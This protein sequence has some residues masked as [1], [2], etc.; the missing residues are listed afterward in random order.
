MKRIIC[1]ITGL[2]LGFGV[3]TALSAGD[4]KTFD[5]MDV[6]SDGYLSF[7]EALPEASI[8]T[9]WPRVDTD[10]NGLVDISEFSA[11]ES[12]ESYTPP[13]EGDAPEPGAAPF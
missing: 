11:F 13:S 3:V 8:T 1:I 7:G 4:A 9:N 12:I 2:V 5:E 10:E 6:N